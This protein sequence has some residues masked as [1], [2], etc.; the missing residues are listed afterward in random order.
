MRRVTYT[1]TVQPGAREGTCAS[2]DELFQTL[3]RERRSCT[4]FVAFDARG[5]VVLQFDP[6]PLAHK[7]SQPREAFR[8]V[9]V[10]RSIGRDR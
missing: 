10:V 1:Y 2:E 5:K 9:P 3:F 4:R 6:A 8:A 7:T